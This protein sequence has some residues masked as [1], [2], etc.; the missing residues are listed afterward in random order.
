MQNQKMIIDIVLKT[1]CITFKLSLEQIF[2][3]YVYMIGSWMYE[4]I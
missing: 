3:E 4:L 1:S 2:I